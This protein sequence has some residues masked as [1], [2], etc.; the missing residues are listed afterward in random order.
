MKYV[1]LIIS[2]VVFSL[3]TASCSHTE[4]KVKKVIRPVQYEKVLFS[5]DEVI[6]TFSGT[7]RT[8]KIINLS[9]RSNGIIT[10]F[11]LKLGQRVKKGQL[12]SKLDNVQS[13]LAYEQA[14]AQLNSAESQMNTA[15]LSLN[16]V[17]SLYEKGSTSLSDL[18]AAKNS[19]KT[20]SQ[21]YEAI[22]R[23][24]AIQQEQ[25]RYGYLY[26]PEDGVISA[27]NVEIDENVRAGQSIAKLNA[28][29]A[30]EIFIG[31]PESAI[32]AI[33]QGMEAD[34][35]F[36]SLPG[37]NFHGTITEIAPSVDQ[38]TST[39]PI[40]VRIKNPITEI[41][42]GMAAN[43]SFHLKKEEV[44]KKHLVVPSY[45]VG[46][47]SDGRFVYLIEEKGGKFFIKKQHVE[48]GALS[49]KGF[50]VRS[51]LSEGQKIATAGLQ[52]L[53]E[54]QEVRLQ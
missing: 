39:Y 11:G 26:A 50:E 9:F 37:V 32:N 25:V 48:I 19:F 44:D 41:K 27:I 29:T 30:M 40:R 52:T 36:A 22:K 14:L 53:L 4:K 45:A 49:G 6:R 35:S 28:G 21:G 51:G 3:M 16:R 20:A 17:M 54:G 8:D 38:N 47:D 7:S 24:V 2:A 10:L 18:E 33:K 1:K 23:G 31:I 43:V 46:E 5:G 12:L 15:K 34:I 13:R 42:S